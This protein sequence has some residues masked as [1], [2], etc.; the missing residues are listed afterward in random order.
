MF[1]IIKRQ[2]LLKEIRKLD[3]VNIF[4]K[5]RY[6]RLKPGD[7]EKVYLPLEDLGLLKDM[8]IKELLKTRDEFVDANLYWMNEIRKLESKS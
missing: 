4:L 5:E 1:K 6:D 8:S 3:E 7:V 2:K